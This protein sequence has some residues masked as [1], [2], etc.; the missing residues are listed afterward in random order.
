MSEHTSRQ[1]ARILIDQAEY[2]AEA[3]LVDMDG[4]ECISMVRQFCAVMAEWQPA[5]RE[6]LEDPVMLGLH[7][8]AAADLFKK[9]FVKGYAE[10]DGRL[11]AEKAIKKALGESE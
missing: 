11:K 9:A 3:M 5:I 10:T 2:L 8:L 6:N 4:P 1:E 7:C